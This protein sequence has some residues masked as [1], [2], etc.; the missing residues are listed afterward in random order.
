MRAGATG[1]GGGEGEV[2][3]MSIYGA[4]RHGKAVGYVVHSRGRLGTLCHGY[5]GRGMILFG[6]PVTLF[7]TRAKAQRAIDDSVSAGRFK[8]NE[9]SIARIAPVVNER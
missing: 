3:D 8:A 9:L 5:K 1:G 4:K 2:K 7:P 6:N